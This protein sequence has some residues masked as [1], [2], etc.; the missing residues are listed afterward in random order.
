MTMSEMHALTELQRDALREV[1][2]IGAGHAATA[3]SLMTGTKILV[4]VPTVTVAPLTELAPPVTATS[5]PVVVI[6]MEMSGSIH[7]QTI[8][9]IP[10]D[11]K[12]KLLTLL[13]HR[14][15]PSSVGLDELETSALLEAG[16]ILVGS[17]MTALSEFLNMRLLPSPPSLD[18]GP[19]RQ[20]LVDTARRLG[21][22]GGDVFCVETQFLVGGID[23]TLPSY[24]LLLPDAG[25]VGMM[26][27]AIR[28]G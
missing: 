22:G 26:L 18:V 5:D 1:A 27:S 6:P 15:S 3:L 19:G 17:Y 14:E 13:L 7:G 24:F 23:N 8:L 11:T 28:V 20:L 10:M 21:Y 9:A 16:N 2:N 25:A 4:S 12:H